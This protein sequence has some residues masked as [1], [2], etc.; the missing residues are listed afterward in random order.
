MIPWSALV[1]HAPLLLAAADKLLA[2]AGSAK[3]D[4]SVVNE[5]ALLLHDLTEQVT[6]LTALQA[7]TA[8]RVRLAVILSGAA[9]VVATGALLV[10]VLS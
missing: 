6:A 10:A 7:H 9:L 1:R 3:P 8:K 4:G 2:R 5:T